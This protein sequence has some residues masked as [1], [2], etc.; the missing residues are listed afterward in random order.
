MIRFYAAYI[1][2]GCD[3]SHFYSN[4]SVRPLLDDFIWTFKRRLVF[5]IL[6]SSDH[7]FIYNYVTVINSCEVFANDVFSIC[8]SLC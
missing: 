2:F 7:N 6:V 8:A 5:I 4:I 1:S 3:R